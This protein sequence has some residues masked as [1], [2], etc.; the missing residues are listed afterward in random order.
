MSA[1]SVRCDARGV[2]FSVAVEYSGG[3]CFLP[4]LV[5]TC[6]PFPESG[7]HGQLC[8]EHSDTSADECTHFP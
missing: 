5:C 8:D 1:S 4:S 6:V 3:C 2:L 7:Y